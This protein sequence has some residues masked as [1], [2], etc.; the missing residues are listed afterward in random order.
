MQKYVQCFIPFISF[1]NSKILQT[2]KFHSSLLVVGNC[3]VT[4]VIITI[5]AEHL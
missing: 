5:K 4:M 1:A 2:K 3:Q